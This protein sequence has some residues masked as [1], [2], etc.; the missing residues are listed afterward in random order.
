MVEQL[1]VEGVTQISFV[2]VRIMINLDEPLV[3]GISVSREEKDLAQVMVKY[4]RLQNIC[5]GCG[6]IYGCES[7][8]HEIRNCKYFLCK[9]FIVSIIDSLD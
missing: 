1:E 4:E 6:R 7:I 9:A 8:G 3:T 5:Y 2:R